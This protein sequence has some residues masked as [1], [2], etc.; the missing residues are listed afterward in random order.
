MLEEVRRES[1]KMAGQIAVEDYHPAPLEP[2][3]DD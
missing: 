2:A 3:A 1:G